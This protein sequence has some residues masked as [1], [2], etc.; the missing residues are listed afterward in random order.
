MGSV[1]G[2]IPV[3]SSCEESLG[4][5]PLALRPA[6]LLDSAAWPFQSADGSE[7]SFVWVALGASVG[8]VAMITRTATMKL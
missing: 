6:G 5:N 3:F 2:K 4:P 1:D 7:A 8:T